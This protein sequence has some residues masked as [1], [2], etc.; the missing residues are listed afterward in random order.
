MPQVPT[1]PENAPFS[2]AQR[3]WLNGFFAGLAGTDEASG[4]AHPNGA[5]ALADASPSDEQ[6]L[7]WREVDDEDVDYAWHDPALPMDERM[8]LAAD[9]PVELRLMAAMAQLDCGSC[10]YLCRSYSKAIADG[11]E[12]DLGKCVPGGKETARMLK[13]IIKDAPAPTVGA[14]GNGQVELRTNGQPLA[15]D[16]APP[17]YG[18]DQP[19]PAPTLAV[20]KLTGDASA[21]DVRFVSLSIAGSGMTYKAGDS[22]GVFPKNCYESVEALVRLTGFGGGELVPLPDGRTMTFREALIEWA[23]IDNPA[24]ELYELLA[25]HASAAEA[26]LLKQAAEGHAVEGLVDEPR[27]IDVL[28]R[29]GSARPSPVKLVAALDRLQPRLYS[30]ASSPKRYPDEIHLCVGVVRYTQAGLPRKGVAST[31][32][33]ERL[34]RCEPVPAYVQPS[35]GFHPPDDGSTDLIMVGP[36][37]GIAPFRAFLQEREATQ[38]TG[39]NWLLFGDQH[40]ASDFLFKDEL[41]RFRDAGVLAKLTTAF[42]RDEAEKIYVQHRMLEHGAELWRWLDGGACFYVCGDASR[43][44][45]DVDAALHQVVATYGDMDEVDAKAYV[46]RMTDEGRYQR[47]VY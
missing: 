10:G 2:A 8:A 3:A 12:T 9:K 24:D 39:R 41:H 15:D 38:A 31:F 36:G 28:A 21:K 16:A 14:T 34:A 26:K 47:D 37:T 1:I 25:S 27:M 35:H 5:A 7:T 45:R 44:A 40:G 30:I 17:Q 22:L 11:D 32:L 4:D 13:K 33:A 20:E 19:F 6:K 46:K 42:S 18:R 29:F 43:M 23:D